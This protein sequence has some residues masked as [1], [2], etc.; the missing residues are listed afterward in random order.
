MMRADAGRFQQEMGGQRPW[1]AMPSSDIYMSYND[2]DPWTAPGV[3][4]QMPP[5]SDLVYDLAGG[6]ISH[7]VDPAVGAQEYIRRWA[8]AAPAEDKDL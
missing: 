7:C 6:G 8:G 3:F 1:E 5:D 2:A 4:Q